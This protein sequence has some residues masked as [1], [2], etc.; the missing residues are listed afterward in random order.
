MWWPNKNRASRMRRVRIRRIRKGFF[1]TILL[2]RTGQ[3]FIFELRRFFVPLA[4]F[5][6]IVGALIYIST[7]DI[8]WQGW[9]LNA[10]YYTQVFCEQIRDG[11]IRQPLNAWS[12]LIFVPIGL[13][14]ARRAFMDKVAS[15]RV[16]PVRRHK[17]YGLLYGTALV[18]T[19]VGSWFFHASLT[20]VGH[21]LDVTGMYFIGAFLL[22]YGL[23]RKLKQSATAFMLA[24]TGVLAPLLVLQWYHPSMSRYAFAGLIAGAAFV[25]ILLH[26]SLRNWLFRG[27][28][29]SLVF[30]FG[31]WI[32]DERK[33][34][35]W[36]QS[37]IQGHALWHVLTALSTHLSYLY[38]IS[39]RPR[40]NWKLHARPGSYTW[41]RRFR[42]LAT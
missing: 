12:S 26:K 25:E 8:P 7:L 29:L 18:L 15:P 22:T 31:I 1:L 36:P 11:S 30:G 3:W 17:R 19:G 20:Y 6:L 9:K 2:E 41:L 32:L 39:E 10:G 23:S 34:L 21:Y 16:A 33:L 4:L 13:W 28:M 14:I 38:Y 37:C 42:N 27:A 35:C 5:V 40:V 24:Y